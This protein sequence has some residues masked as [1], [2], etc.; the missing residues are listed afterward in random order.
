M[1]TVPLGNEVGVSVIAG[2]I[3]T[4][5]YIRV[6]MQPS[7]SVAPTVKLKKPEVVGV[8]EST[9][10]DESMVRPGGVV[11]LTKLKEYGPVP[12][13]AVRVWLYGEPSA[14]SGML[15]GPTF[16]AL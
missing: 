14:P 8:P 9:P 5:A 16:R 1:P 15:I 13:E 11:P 7:A 12:P 6:P 2:Q 10:E 3:I 4:F